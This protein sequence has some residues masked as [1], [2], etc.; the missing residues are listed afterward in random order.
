MGLLSWLFSHK[1]DVPASKQVGPDMRFGDSDVYFKRCR[2]HPNAP[3][4]I[5]N[6]I[7][8]PG[9]FQLT[10]VTCNECGKNTGGAVMVPRNAPVPKLY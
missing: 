10:S 2:E 3:I 5:G 8:K 4:T 1:R 7:C 6:L 9:V